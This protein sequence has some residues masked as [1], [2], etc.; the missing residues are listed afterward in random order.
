MKTKT[1]ALS[2]ASLLALSSLLAACSSGSEGNPDN[3]AAADASGAPTEISIFT[4]QQGAQA[5][6]PANPIFQ[7]IMKKTNTKL[8]ITWVPFN[9]LTEKT[10]VMLASGDIPELTYVSNV[11]DSQ[12]V[13]MAASGA[14]WDL[15][16]YIKD[17]KNFS[18]LPQAIWDNAKIQGKNYGIPR[19]RPLEGS[20]GAHVRKDWLD[21]LGLPVP[22]TMDDLYQVLQAFT[23]KDPDGNGK[24]DTIGL[25]GEVASDNMGSLGWVENVFNEV[26]GSYKLV[27]GQLTPVVLEPS[28]RQALEWLKKAYEEKV[29]VPDFPVLK[30]SQSREQYMGSKAGV[31]GVAI[32]PQWLFTDAI[33]K[34]DPKG[35]SYPLPYLM[36][37]SGR[38]FAGRDS[39]VFGMYVIPKTVPEAK[40]KKI[41]AFMDQAYSEE[42][43][44]LAGFGFPDKHYTVKDGFKIA[45]EQAKADNV[46]DTT[47]NLLQIFQKYDMYA[48]AYYNGIPKE[49][50]DRNKKIIDEREAI[51]VPDP[52]YGLISQTALTAGPDLNKKIQDMKTKVIMG[53]ESLAAWDEFTAK[54]K[55]DATFTKITQEIN[56]AYKQK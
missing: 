53:K 42:I 34:I 13:Q 28:E 7:E 36:G 37:P 14:F 19:P 30:N 41:L 33:R 12:V 23:H 35:D 1:I 2:A 17:Y 32:N 51:S 8:N 20:W 21:N 44:D 38:K 3:G 22:E 40:M 56:E 31:L 49:F 52:A 54:L 55:A 16:P 48:R 11:F 4:N 45:T 18:A 47:N 50:Y 9:T 10:K 46:A 39:G 26:P 29:L 27:N 24:A 6:D 25:V 43:G 5:V 15:T